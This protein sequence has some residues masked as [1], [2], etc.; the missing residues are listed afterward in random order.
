MSRAVFLAVGLV[1]AIA[2]KTGFAAPAEPKVFDLGGLRKVRVEIVDSAD[3]Y[4]I[5]AT[6]LPVVSLSPATN[7]R[8][9]RSKGESYALHALAEHLHL[10]KSAE[11][12]VSRMEVRGSGMKGDFY[13]LSLAIPRSAIAAGERKPIRRTQTGRPP[14][15]SGPRQRSGESR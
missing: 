6:F 5:T 4:L 8:I 10:G 13:R 2:L 11:F 15:G 7:A 14:A 1:A 3:A 9:N 12:T